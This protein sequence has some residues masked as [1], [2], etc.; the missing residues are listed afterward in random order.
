MC[1]VIF[2]TAFSNS[3][4]EKAELFFCF[5]KIVLLHFIVNQYITLKKKQCEK[6]VFYE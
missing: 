2:I 6:L 1:N 5:Y 4:K 3:Q